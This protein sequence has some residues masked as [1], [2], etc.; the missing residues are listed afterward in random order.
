MDDGGTLNTRHN[1]T[2]NNMQHD[3]YMYMHMCMCMH[4]HVHVLH[5]HVDCMAE[6]HTRHKISRPYTPCVLPLRPCHSSCT[7]HH[8]RHTTGHQSLPVT[9]TAPPADD[10]EV[11]EACVEANHAPRIEQL[12]HMNQLE[13]GFGTRPLPCSAQLRPPGRATQWGRG[14]AAR[15]P[16]LTCIRSY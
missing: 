3:M 2:H 14:T 6:M 7:L 15:C 1:E 16:V 5:A 11:V 13:V 10:L 12:T 8:T 4:V 9:A